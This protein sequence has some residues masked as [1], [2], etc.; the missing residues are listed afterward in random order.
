MS[1]THIQMQNFFTL[2]I[3]YSIIAIVI[4]IILTKNKSGFSIIF[5]LIY[6]FGGIL[7]AMFPVI[8]LRLLPSFIEEI[9]SL[10]FLHG[11]MLFMFLIVPITA[12]IGILDKIWELKIFNGVGAKESIVN[13]GNKTYIKRTKTNTL[14]IYG[15]ITSALA[16]E[17]IKNIV[18]FINNNSHT[19]TLVRIAIFGILVL[20]SLGLVMKELITKHINKEKICTLFI[21]LFTMS[22]IFFG[23]LGTK[24][25]LDKELYIKTTA[26]YVE[27]Q[28][29]SS[30]QEE[31]DSS[32]IQ[33]E[34]S[35]ST[36]LYRYQYTVDGSNYEI[37]D[38]VSKEKKHELGST[39]EIYY[40]KNDKSLNKRIKPISKEYLTISGISLVTVAILIFI[41]NINNKNKS[42]NNLDNNTI[43]G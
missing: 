9:E 23:V 41:N 13:Y 36:M 2:G 33:T 22:G 14:G 5:S 20:I 31:Q 32:N 40:H 17:F 18:I 21:L 6:C 3:I 12:Y 15:I 29:E 42:I 28:K 4:K 8:G 10:S 34:Q 35:D 43:G 38:S 30:I 1:F 24:N 25:Y 7:L 27:Y 39:K 26:V 11:I 16:L 37:E 19:S